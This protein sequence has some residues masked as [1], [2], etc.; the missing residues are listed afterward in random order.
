MKKLFVL[1]LG[2]FLFSASAT[3][4]KFGYIN[5]QE[6]LVSLPEVKAADSELEAFQKQLMTKGQELVA[7]F[8]TEYKAYVEE[9]N[10]GLLSKVQMQKKEEDLGVKQ[11]TI[12]DYEQEVQLKLSQKRETIYK[13]ILD[14][15]NTTITAFGKENGYTMI[16]DSSAGNLLFVQDSDNLFEAIK[17][18]LS[19]ASN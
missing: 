5:S 18:K 16:F 8:E 12:Q 9:A 19:I 10:K 11:K 4:Q 2:I 17:A 7:T 15:I 1:A 3:A 13:P 14:K 6:L